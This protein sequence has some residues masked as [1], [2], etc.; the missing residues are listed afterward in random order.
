M[1]VRKG[2]SLLELIVVIA[3]LAVLIA[4]LVPAIQ[5]G[6][7]AAIRMQSLNNLR[8]LALGLHQLSDVE[9][10]FIGGY[11]KADPKSQQEANRLL[12]SRHGNPQT[13]ILLVLEGP[14][15][16][17]GWEGLRK[18]LI[19]PAD[20]SDMSGPKTRAQ[21]TD[22]TITLEYQAGGPCS[23]AFNMVAFLGP[24]QFPTDIRDGTSN[25]IAFSERYYE[26]FFSTVPLYGDFYPTSWLCYADGNSALPSPFPPFPMNDRGTRR[27]SFADAGW[28]D[29]LPVTTG[30]PP[31][32]QPSV[33]GV[34]FQVQPPLHFADAYRL[35]T[36]F[37]AGLPVAMFD[38]SVRTISPSVSPETFWAAVT[39]AGAEVAT[40]D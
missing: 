19:S 11:V 17:G 31:V 4:F 39:P 23:Y 21:G 36:P 22:G 1:S 9:D 7:E 8:Q 37:A 38:G 18:Y 33:P 15:P 32:T 13:W 5:K 35:Q 6:R 26:R 28:G 14:P 2:F 40:S 25:T 30:D 24:P 29:V 20:P 16:P 12:D 10:G 3:I 34:T 27:P